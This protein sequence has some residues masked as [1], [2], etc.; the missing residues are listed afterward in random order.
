MGYMYCPLNRATNL[1]NIR[2]QP[3]KLEMKH[4]PLASKI[5]DHGLVFRCFYKYR[6]KKIQNISALK[7]ISAYLYLYIHN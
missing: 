4:F 2:D 1:T 3:V 7:D 6:V 5:T